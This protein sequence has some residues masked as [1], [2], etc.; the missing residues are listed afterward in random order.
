MLRKAFASTARSL[1]R[2]TRS[3]LFGSLLHDVRDAD[4]GLKTSPDKEPNLPPECPRCG[5][6][7]T[8][9]ISGICPECG[10]PIDPA[11][12]R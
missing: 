8:G 5:Y 4:I 2:F 3:L 6:D 12:M 9:N 1:W 7:L 10:T 11:I